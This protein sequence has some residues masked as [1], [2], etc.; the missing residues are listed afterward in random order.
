M[1]LNKQSGNMYPFVTHTR[2]PIRD[3]CPHQ[4]THCYM[5]KFRVGNLRLEEKEFTTNLGNSNL[6]FIGSSTDIWATEV[7][8]EWIRK[9]LEYTENYNNTYLFQTKN[10]I[11]RLSLYVTGY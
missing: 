5:K 8:S 4:C 11:E 7:L 6:I 9:L 2:N 10:P 3:H 1:S